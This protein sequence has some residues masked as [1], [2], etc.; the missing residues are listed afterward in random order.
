MLISLLA[1]VYIVVPISDG[2][3]T[4]PKGTVGTVVHIHDEDNFEVEFSEPGAVL[5][6]R[7][8]QIQPI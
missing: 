1:R 3:T 5:C 7:R 8:Q 2:T 6:V 4:V